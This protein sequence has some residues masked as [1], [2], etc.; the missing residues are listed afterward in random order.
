[1][2]PSFIIIED[3]R[4]YRYSFWLTSD[5]EK[6]LFAVFFLF[7]LK[8]F[9]SL[10]SISYLRFLWKSF[11]V[12]TLLYINTF[13]LTR[14]LLHNSD[15]SWAWMWFPTNCE[16]HEIWEWQKSPFVVILSEK[17]INFSASLREIIEI[18]WIGREWQFTTYKWSKTWLL[19]IL[20]I[21]F[22][23]REILTIAFERVFIVNVN[24]LI[25]N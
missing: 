15:G 14:C 4:Q 16:K 7:F 19:E 18:V 13:L 25:H 20:T 5:K 6:K 22:E 23:L 3:G 10:N 2:L 1:M 11:E 8:H 9:F 24:S 12:W 21:A 17:L